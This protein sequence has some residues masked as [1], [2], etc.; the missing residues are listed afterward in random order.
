MNLTDDSWQPC[1][2][3][4]VPRLSA[5]FVFEPHFSTLSSGILGAL[6]EIEKAR[7]L[8][9]KYYYLGYIVP[10]CAKMTYKCRL[11]PHQLYSRAAETWQEVEKPPN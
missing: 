6:R 10:E 7:S 8:G 2:W 3:I 11:Y 5:P 1:I 9:I 4:T